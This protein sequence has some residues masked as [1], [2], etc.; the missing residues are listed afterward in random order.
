MLRKKKR[1]GEAQD[2]IVDRPGPLSRWLVTGKAKK[3]ESS[4]GAWHRAYYGVERVLSTSRQKGGERNVDKWHSPVAMSQNNYRSS[5]G[6]W[7]R[8]ERVE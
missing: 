6:S 5:H 8:R 7:L 2:K 1:G 4:K 3:V